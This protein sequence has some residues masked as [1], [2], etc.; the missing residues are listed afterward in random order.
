MTITSDV[1]RKIYP[2][3]SAR[4]EVVSYALSKICPEYGIDTPDV[5]H[6]FIANLIEECA[7]FTKFDENLNYSA[8]RLM[9]VWKSRFPTLE[10]AEQYAHNPKKLAEKVYM[11]RMGN[12]HAGDGYLF[13]GGGAIQITGRDYY[14]LFTT[15]YNN[16]FNTKIPINTMAELIRTD[17]EMAIHSACW[18]FAIAKGLINLAVNDDMK[19]IVKRINGGLTNFEERMKYYELA[20][21][22]IV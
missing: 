2:L 21:K 19:T 12:I 15:F 18:V 6:E 17:I 5:M 3:S 10:I 22:Y 14:T 20:K 9:Q 16:K 13:R 8:P 7:G 1:L 11:N 4:A